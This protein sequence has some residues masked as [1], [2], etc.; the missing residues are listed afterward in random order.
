MEKRKLEIRIEKL[1]ER[2]PALNLKIIKKLKRRLRKL[3][4]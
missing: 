1:Q 4:N 3:E 2:D